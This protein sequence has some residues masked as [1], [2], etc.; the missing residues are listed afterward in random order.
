MYSDTRNLPALLTKKEFAAHIRVST[1]TVE[2][3]M[4]AGK[5]GFYMLD[6]GPRFSREDLQAF[7]DAKRFPAHES[8]FRGGKSE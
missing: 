1:R 5:I 8:Y 7:L 2:K 4:K 6:G 3:L